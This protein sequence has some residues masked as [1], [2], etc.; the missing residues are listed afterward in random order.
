MST[1]SELSTKDRAALIQMMAKEGISSL[2]EMEEYYNT[3]TQQADTDEEYSEEDESDAIFPFEASSQ[4]GNSSL[5]SGNMTTGRQYYIKPDGSIGIK[6]GN[7]YAFGGN[8]RKKIIDENSPDF[9][10]PVRPVETQDMIDRQRYAESTYNDNAYNKGSKATGAFQITPSVLNEYT[11]RTGKTGDLYDYDFNRDVRDWYMNTRLREFEMNRLGNPADSVSVG[12]RYAAFNAGPGKVRKALK[13]AE[14]EG[15]DINT[16]FDWLD[17]LPKETQDYVNFIVR[18]QDIPDSSKT[19]QQF[20]DV[21]GFKDGGKI[22]IKPEN[23]GKFT[24]LKKRTGHSATWFKQ[25]GTP[26]Q[27]KMAVFALNA[28][29]WKHSNG[30]QLN[31][32][33]YALGGPINPNN[34]LPSFIGRRKPLPDVRY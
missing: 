32:A 2:D 33:P 34:Y 4:Q 16:S 7:T 30:G 28:R 18:G 15:A 5:S 25:H 13:Q 12:R 10:G 23:R 1:W 19:N 31:L 29:K 17:Y 11:Q 27:K 24:A 14:L 20:I 8:R 9:V 6:E 26:A 3:A 22:H 21:R